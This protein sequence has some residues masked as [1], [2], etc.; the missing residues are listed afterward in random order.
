MGDLDL[1]SGQFDTHGYDE[2][3]P[4]WYATTSSA[5]TANTLYIAEADVR[6]TDLVETRF[7]LRSVEPA[8]AI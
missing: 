8:T 5:P 7:G 6:S 2:T 3:F 1:K 4:Y